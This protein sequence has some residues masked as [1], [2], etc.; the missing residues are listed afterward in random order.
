MNDVL[1]YAQAED[2]WELERDTYREYCPQMVSAAAVPAGLFVTP[3]VG[4]AVKLCSRA[5]GNAV[6][7]VIVYQR[8]RQRDA[9]TASK[10]ISKVRLVGRSKQED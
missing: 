1:G 10:G 3:I 5:V 2:N 8:E 9:E 7:Y 4:V 6:G